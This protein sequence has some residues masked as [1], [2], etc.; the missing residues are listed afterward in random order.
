MGREANRMGWMDKKRVRTEN[1]PL[2][3]PA[4]HIPFAILGVHGTDGQWWRAAIIK[5]VVRTPA[6]HCKPAARFAA[7]NS[8]SESR[9]CCRHCM[10]RA[11]S[12]MVWH[13]GPAT[14]GFGLLGD[15]KVLCAARAG[16]GRCVEKEE[17]PCLVCVRALRTPGVLLGFCRD[18]RD[19]VGTL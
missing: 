3:S 15:G 17:A 19:A 11:K 18:A 10:M 5:M 16:V 4:G 6:C 8:E 7:R 1:P 9:P 14:A 13:E 2:P 12:F